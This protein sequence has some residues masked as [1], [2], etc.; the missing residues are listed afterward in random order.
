[1]NF[2]HDPV[3]DLL[4][5]EHPSQLVL[6]HI[7]EAR[8]ING[9]YVAVPRTLR[10]SQVLRW[11]NYPVVPIM[12]KY[13]WPIEPGRKALPHQKLMANYQVL[14]PRCFNL[15]DPG[16]M[17][18][19]ASLWAAD[20]IMQQ[21][22]PGKCRCLIVG[23][24]NVIE[25]V[26]AH[27]IFSNFLGRRTFEILYGDADKRTKLLAKKPDF[28]IINVDGV[29]VGARTR[30]KP[31]VLDGFSKILNADE[32]IK[33]VILDEG[34]SYID[35]TTARHHV[36]R[37]IFNRRPYVWMLTGTPCAQAPTDAYGLGKL[38][39]NAYGKSFTTFRDETMT[40]VSQFKWKP[41][42]DGY[43][44]AFQLLTPAIRVDIRDTWRDAPEMTTQQRLVPLTE[45]Q[46]KALATLKRDFQVVLQSGKAINAV[47]EGAVRTKLLQTLLGAV[48]DD[49]HKAHKLDADP[50]Y[51][52]IER[53]IS[54]TT[55]KVLIFI[56]FTSI[57][58]IALERLSRKW[59]CA[60]I[61]GGVRP[62]DRPDIIRSFEKEPD[63]KC[64]LVDAQS[65]AHGI[66]EFVVA[67]TVIWMSAIDKTRLYIQGNRR[68][69]RPGQKW[70]VTVY[71]L[72]AH[73]LEI[74]MFKRLETNTSMQGLL[75]DMVRKGEL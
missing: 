49:A 28:A 42:R 73:K 21:F 5:Y 61:N 41:K 4:I 38:M 6:Q 71:Q 14:Q 72:V 40:K 24:L 19:L 44:K 58:D 22:P 69:H 31:V 36:A 46:K 63:L 20:F 8:A 26:W 1:M 30:K 35:D 17:K 27:A 10:N 13:D 39:N 74:E 34:D 9:T 52:E 43:E 66:N 59:R 62:K 67:D 45:E 65:V 7:P 64:M 68:A 23:L 60:V 15:S 16:T 11:L 25:T 54:S 48:Y 12:E 55:R 2:F 53:I 75:L 70:P 51:V 29:A 18:T 57:V 47:N 37:Q 56:P 33:I 32:D 50:R 3:R